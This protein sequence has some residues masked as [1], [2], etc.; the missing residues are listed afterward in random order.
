MNRYLL[1]S[2]IFTWQT[3]GQL[4]GSYPQQRALTLLG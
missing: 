3:D 2:Q 4:Y 1:S